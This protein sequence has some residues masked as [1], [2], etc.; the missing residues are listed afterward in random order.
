MY[1]YPSLVAY[2]L[3]VS[4]FCKKNKNRI[5]LTH[6]SDGGIKTIFESIVKQND[7]VIIFS[8]TFEMYD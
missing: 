4:K 7:K 2:M 6:G 5:L 1:S 3:K 8:P